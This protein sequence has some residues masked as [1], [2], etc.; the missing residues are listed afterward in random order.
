MLIRVEYLSKLG[1]F[2]IYNVYKL[3]KPACYVTQTLK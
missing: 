1:K 2:G 3:T